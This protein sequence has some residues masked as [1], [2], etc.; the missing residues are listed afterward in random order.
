MNMSILRM[1]CFLFPNR[2]FFLGF[3]ILFSNE[4][5]GQL[6]VHEGN[7]L[8]K[9]SHEGAWYHNPEKPGEVWSYTQSRWVKLLA[10]DGRPPFELQGLIWIPTKEHHALATKTGRLIIADASMVTNNGLVF[11]GIASG[12]H[13]F[14][15]NSKGDTLSYFKFTYPTRHG[16]LHDPGWTRVRLG[17]DH[18]DV[19]PQFAPSTED[20]LMKQL[21]NWGMLAADGKWVI[22]P[23]YD[24]PFHFE[25]GVADVLYYSQ[26]RKINDKGEF[27]E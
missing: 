14:A 21:R 1:K 11:L 20:F 23:I 12:D 6:K 24:A 2:L 8:P 25:N 10:G 26:K 15:I 18:F 16:S 9:K 5:F 7:S 4:V 3:A 13:F 19:L 22:E 27:V 17:N